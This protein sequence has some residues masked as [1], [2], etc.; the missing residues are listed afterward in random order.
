MLWS[1]LL[2]MSLGWGACPD[3]PVLSVDAA[4]IEIERSFLAL[5]EE[6][7][8]LARE[9]LRWGI[10]CVGEAL[11]RSVAIQLHRA[12]AVLAFYDGDAAASS[13][14]W[15][16]LRD[17]DDQTPEGLSPPL[18]ALYDGAP[19][20]GATRSFDEKPG[21]AWVVDGERRSEVPLW[22][23]FVLQVLGPDGRAYYTDYL[24][25]VADVPV[26][27]LVELP[28]SAEAIK[29]MHR[30]RQTRARSIGSV[31]AGGMLAGSGAFLALH[32][33][34]RRELASSDLPVR[35]VEA[36]QARANL[37]GGM[38]AGLATVG[39]GVATVVWTVRW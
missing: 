22:R 13:R 26:R 21:E 4:A 34:Q 8:R 18:R 6:W 38:S 2:A 32:L 24:H 33:E 20:G 1:W 27:D 15:A 9:R 28:E 5:D 11:P 23:G 19:R 17:L 39:V 12:F 36:A 10:L 3:N 7:L 14:S 25:S 31:L 30:R 37:Y 35:E 16:A 29:A